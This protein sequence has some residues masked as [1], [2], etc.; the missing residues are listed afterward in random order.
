MSVLYTMNFLSHYY[1]LPEKENTDKVAGNLLPDL[2][3]GFT[4]IYHQEIKPIQEINQSDIVKGIHYHLETDALFHQHQF[5]IDH[6]KDLKQIT[7]SYD[8]PMTKNYI[9]SHV[10]LELIIDQY[11]MEKEANLAPAFYES[12]SQAL[13]G[14]L[15]EKIKMTVS[16]QNSKKII[17]IFRS[18]TDSQYAYS[19]QKNTGIQEALHQIIGKRIGLTFQEANWG[20][21]IQE[22]K[23]K[24]SEALPSFLEHLKDELNY[25]EKD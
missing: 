23:E 7:A 11:L 25:A 17:S 5:F 19:L 20:K 4:K 10:L 3:R 8:L 15:E 6:C 13:E 14:E 9:V 21:A 22:G 18:F 24:I 2:M 12:L 16:R 1:L